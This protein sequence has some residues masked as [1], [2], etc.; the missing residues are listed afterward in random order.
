MKHQRTEV[1]KLQA[2]LDVL[3]EAIIETSS[4]ELRY[5][6]ESTGSSADEIIASVTADINAAV[7]RYRRKALHA[8]RKGYQEAV[9]DVG[10]GSEMSSKDSTGARKLLQKILKKNANLSSPLTLA[11]REGKELSDEDLRTLLQ[12]LADLGLQIDESEQ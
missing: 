3:E 1:E 5:E 2:V 11:A 10:S 12:D 7:S 9:A 4:E 8:A 6:I